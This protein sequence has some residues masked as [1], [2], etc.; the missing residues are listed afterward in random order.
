VNLTCRVKEFV[1]NFCCED[2]S[3]QYSFSGQAAMELWWGNFSIAS[4]AIE[5]VF[6]K[7]IA[8]FSGIIAANFARIIPNIYFGFYASIL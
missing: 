3:C 7:R 2:A 8:L 6:E 4:L 5:K 1:V